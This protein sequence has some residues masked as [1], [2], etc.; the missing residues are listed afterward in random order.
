MENREENISALESLK[1]RLNEVQCV[2]YGETLSLYE[3]VNIYKELLSEE[4]TQHEIEEILEEKISKDTHFI[5][6]YLDL[7][8]ALTLKIIVD[9]GKH[10]ELC[11][12]KQEEKLYLIY[13]TP[14][15]MA[16]SLIRTFLTEGYEWVKREYERHIYE[17]SLSSENLSFSVNDFFIQIAAGKQKISVSYKQNLSFQNPNIEIGIFGVECS[18]REGITYRIK[19]SQSDIYTWLDGNEEKVFNQIAVPLFFLPSYIRVRA[20]EKKKSKSIIGVIEKKNR[21]GTLLDFLKGK[22]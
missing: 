19:T 12:Q 9:S 15:P 8:E 22:V 14:G 13:A 21:R 16:D 20:E 18:F 10:Y 6:S 5:S 1:K 2:K 17:S 11:F 7:E 4:D 3:C